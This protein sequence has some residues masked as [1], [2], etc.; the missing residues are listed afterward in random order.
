MTHAGCPGGARAERPGSIVAA[1]VSFP[2]PTACYYRVMP[3]RAEV[4][5]ILADGRFHSGT[6]V[7]RVLGV[8][9][10]AV[11]KCVRTLAGLGLDIHRV[12]GRG[13][14]LGAAMEA[15]DKAR[16]LTHLGPLRADLADRVTILDEVDS[17]SRYLMR[18]AATDLVS[19]AVCL[20]E[21]QTQGRGRRGRNWIATPYANIL[22]S[23]AWRFEAGSALVAGLSLAAGVATVRALQEY[24]VD[25]V[26]LK[27]PNDVLVRERKLAG[28]LVEVHGEAS[29]PCLVVLGL[30]VNARLSSV[31]GARIE[32]PWIDLHTIAASPVDRNHLAALLIRHLYQMFECFARTGLANF[33]ADWEQLHV[34]AGRRV[35]V[36]YAGGEFVG[37]ALG[38][39]DTGAL[40]V[41]DESGRT[42]QFLSGEVSLRVE[43]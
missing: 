22:L 5:K 34:Y 43:A 27:W 20:G 11:N 23:M 2:T 42:R 31:D 25:G 3:T 9:R 6:D 32:Q 41:L 37:K 26:G 33:R 13:Y 29:G 1:P 38:A 10:A 17:T 28:L 39:D 4:L 40:I 7:G 8:S 12:P 35:R 16:I 21:A 15:L 30:G 18:R 36:S 19:G 24:G 14:R